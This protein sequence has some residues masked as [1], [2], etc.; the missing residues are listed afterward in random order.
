MESQHTREMDKNREQDRNKDTA[1]RGSES[2]ASTGSDGMMSNRSGHE[3][4]ERVVA[5][6]AHH[7]VLIGGTGADMAAGEV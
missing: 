2:M 5:D 7:G 6:L 1:R 3:G 4:V